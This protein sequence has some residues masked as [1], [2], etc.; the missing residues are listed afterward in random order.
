MKSLL[1]FLMGL[2]PLLLGIWEIYQGKMA[3]KE[4]HWQY[5]NQTAL[6]NR[7]LSKIKNTIHKK[8]QKKIIF[9][10]AESCLMENYL[11]SIHR[12]HR[13]HEPPS[14]G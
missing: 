14:A 4:L 9:E 1:V 2:L 11:W 3:I 12:Y 13:E 6:F 10:L 7:A 8:H 5:K